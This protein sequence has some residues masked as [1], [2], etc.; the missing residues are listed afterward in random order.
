MK[1][2]HKKRG[3]VMPALILIALAGVF[4]LIFHMATPTVGPAPAGRALRYHPVI[5]AGH[6]GEDG[7]ASSDAGAREAD[8]NLQVAVKTDLLMRFMGVSTTMT[9]RED[10]SL[11]DATA[12]TFAEKKRSDLQNRAALVEKMK[13]ALLLSIHQN[14]FPESKYFGLQAFYGNAHGSRELADEIQNTAIRR[15]DPDNTRK[16]ATVR[17]DIYLMNQVTCPAVLV[18]CGFLTNPREERLL[19]EDTYQT[20]LAAVITAAYLQWELGGF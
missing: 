18:E 16:A 12:R 4:W 17:E 3:L 1:K 20:K 6:G 5:D 19:R 14:T 9:R 15:L 10:I 8:I 2:H 7:G 11:H 13:N